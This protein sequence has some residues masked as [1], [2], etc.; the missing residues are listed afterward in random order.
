M[1]YSIF[2]VSEKFIYE[3]LESVERK[4]DSYIVIKNLPGE[5]SIDLD[6]I[7]ADNLNYSSV[8][9]IGAVLGVNYPDTKRKAVFEAKKLGINLWQNL[10]DP[11]SVVSLS[12]SLGAGIYVNA[13][14]II[15]SKCK[16]SDF[17]SFNRGS[18]IGHHVSIKEFTSIG[19]GA[20]VCG[21]VEIDEGTFLGA[22]CVIRD[23]VKIG[24]NCV[25]G[26]GAVVVAD[27]ADN[28]M[29]VGNPAK[30]IKK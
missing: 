20:I 17:V 2:G 4:N 27:V 1:K 15:G 8:F 21:Q 12:T 10:I 6:Y 14:V 26:A 29:V 7:T 23:K 30:P 11:N 18:M 25:I 22:G 9:E 16:I 3:I 28:S 13:G 19:P 24:K 5:L